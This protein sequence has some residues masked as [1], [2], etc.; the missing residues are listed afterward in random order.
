MN[1]VILLISEQTLPNCIFI[2]E[3]GQRAIDIDKYIF[4]S[5]KKMEE[6]GRSKWIKLSLDLDNK[7]C[8]TW[9]IEAESFPDAALVLT[10]KITNILDTAKIYLNLTGGTKMMSIAAF[11][12]F[13]NHR[14]L[15]A[16]YMPLGGKILQEIY[17]NSNESPITAK[18]NLN[19]YLLT[20]GF[21]FVSTVPE[22]PETFTQ[23]FFK[24]VQIRNGIENVH[25]V[26]KYYQ[27]G[28]TA[29]EKQYYTGGWWEEFLYSFIKQELK[30]NKKEIALNLKLKH[31]NTNS[32]T[33]SDTEIDV[34]FVFENMLYIIECKVYVTKIDSRKINISLYKLGAIQTTLGLH[35]K[36]FL[37]TPSRKDTISSGT[38]NRIILLSKSLKIK[39]FLGL[40][41]IG[42]KES[43]FKT[44]IS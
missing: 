13:V 43:F 37:M 29:D 40:S 10:E 7:K 5:T 33:D 32:H 9:I 12:C 30:L 44:L 36:C 21:S 14:G 19:E 23:N 18:V 2:K 28:F 42:D 11:Q 17:P 41:E 35:S 38:L 27:I 20:Y 15:S 22:K 25:E 3:L 39:D 8:E 6:Q 24:K 16:F 1:I 26:K 34:A 31:L 4:I